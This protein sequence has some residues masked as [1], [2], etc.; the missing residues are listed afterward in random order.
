[1]AVLLIASS[2][3]CELLLELFQTNASEELAIIDASN[4]F[5]NEVQFNK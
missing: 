3:V 2:E 4:T 1:M 5:I